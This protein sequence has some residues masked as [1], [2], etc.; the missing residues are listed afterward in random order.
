MIVREEDGEEAGGEGDEEG[1]DANGGMDFVAG[2]G[3]GEV[4]ADGGERGEGDGAEEEEDGPEAE[5]AESVD[6]FSAAE[7]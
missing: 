4:E 3:D 1:V 5:G 2:D 6:G 7:K